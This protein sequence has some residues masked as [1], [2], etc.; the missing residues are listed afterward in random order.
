MELLEVLWKFDS[1]NETVQKAIFDSSEYK[2]ILNAGLN[3]YELREAKIII[4]KKYAYLA[5]EDKYKT[6]E[7]FDIDGILVPREWFIETA[8]KENKKKAPEP[9]TPE[10]VDP[11][12]LKEMMAEN[13]AIEKLVGKF[14]LDIDN[15]D[16]PF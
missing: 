8:P 10:P 16:L 2:A 6:T 1:W 3:D 14:G 13:P 15:D 5:L 12:L 11:A 7:G 9:I 4:A